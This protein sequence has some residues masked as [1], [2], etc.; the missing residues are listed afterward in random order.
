MTSKLQTLTTDWGY[1]A[2]EDLIEDYMFDGLMPAICINEGC[3][4]STEY[5]PDQDQGWCESCGT[6]TVQSATI[7]AGVI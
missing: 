4:Y 5:E 1:Q 2:P 7:L 6:N 3:D